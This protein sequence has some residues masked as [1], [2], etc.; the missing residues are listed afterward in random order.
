MIPSGAHAGRVVPNPSHDK[1]HMDVLSDLLQHLTLESEL[2]VRPRTFAPWGLSM[3][4]DADAVFH[5][6]VG[7]G[8]WLRVQGQ[9]AP[10]QLHAGD[11]VL[12]PQGH[13]HSLADALDSP[14]QSIESL[15][16]ARTPEQVAEL[17]VGGEGRETMIVSG[18]YRYR[19]IGVH[20]LLSPLP[21]L[22]HVR[23]GAGWR[24]MSLEHGVH[25]LSTEVACARAGAARIVKSLLEVLFLQAVRYDIESSL[26]TEPS[27]LRGLRDARIATA[28]GCIH[29]QPAQPWTTAALAQQAGMSR[30]AF[31][32]QFMALLG[33]PPPNYLTRWRIQTALRALR[34]A[35]P[36]LSE[37]AT[38]VGYPSTAAFTRI[39]KR[40]VGMPPA[41]YRR[42]AAAGHEPLLRRQPLPGGR[43]PVY[44]AARFRRG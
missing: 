11:F 10:L 1:T 38:A 36:P 21:A 7:G 6:L 28:L 33:E 29:G 41:D 27:W 16:A 3:Q 24:S 17:Q 15:V 13:A 43:A 8:A 9:G 44:A 2:F 37:V 42:A 14:L 35:T 22:V 31:A 12:L 32:A 39:F 5:L 23:A 19:R 18:C 25:L 30:P 34:Q 20:P 26:T 40:M 4:A